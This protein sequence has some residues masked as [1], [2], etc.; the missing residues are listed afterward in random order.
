MGTWN[1]KVIGGRDHDFLSIV[2]DTS[3]ISALSPSSVCPGKR[4]SFQTMQFSA[5]AYLALPLD[6]V[7]E[8]L[9]VCLGTGMRTIVPSAN[10]FGPNVLLILMLHST[11]VRPISLMMGNTLKGRCTPS[12]MRYFMRSNSPSGGTKLTQ[13]S[14]WKRLRLTHWWNV[15]SSISMLFPA[16]A[17]PPARAGSCSSVSLSF[18][19]SLRSGIPERKHFITI[20][21]ATSARSTV[22][23]ADISM[24][25]LSIISRKTSLRL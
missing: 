17:P 24:L 4:R 9:A 21:P 2:V 8:A 13:R 1:S 5:A 22:P 7:M 18:R 20:L 11:R 3:S 10:S 14:S 12:V 23:F 16:P 25:M 15:M 19:P 6:T